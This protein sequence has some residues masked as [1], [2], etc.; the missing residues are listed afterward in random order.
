[1]Y[2]ASNMIFEVDRHLSSIT[3][4]DLAAR[5]TMLIVQEK[6]TLRTV[7]DR[8]PYLVRNHQADTP[9]VLPTK[10]GPPLTFPGKSQSQ[11]QSYPTPHAG[12]NVN[13]R[14]LEDFRALPLVLSSTTEGVA[15]RAVKPP[16]ISHRPSRLR[17]KT[18]AKTEKGTRAVSAPPTA[19]S[20]PIREI[21]APPAGLGKHL[22]M[23]GALPKLVHHLH[24]LTSIPVHQST[25]LPPLQPK[26]RPRKLT[27]PRR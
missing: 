2:A 19:A 26:P 1:M 10:M 24:L 7:S 18:R 12:L 17:R 3:K 21:L 13:G 27:R 8:A 9:T 14:L 25:P 6:M 5:K 11:S 22:L 16:A 23:S 15:E 4:V 20:R